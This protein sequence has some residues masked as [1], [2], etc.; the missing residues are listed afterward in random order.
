M[1]QNQGGAPL[2]RVQILD[3]QNPSEGSFLL[4]EPQLKMKPK[5]APVTQEGFFVGWVSVFF[6]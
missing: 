2:L 5:T 3:Q 1:L 4:L 6:V